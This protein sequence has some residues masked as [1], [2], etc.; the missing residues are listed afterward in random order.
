MYKVI[1][2][3]SALKD[4]HYETLEWLKKRGIEPPRAR[5]KK[6]GGPTENLSGGNQQVEL[7]LAL[8]PVAI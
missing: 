8:N 4:L 7:E 1:L 3:R 2:V 5:S 6:T